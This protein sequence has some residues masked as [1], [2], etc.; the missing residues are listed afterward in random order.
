M[1]DLP[2]PWRLRAVQEQD[3]A[4]LWQLYCSSRDDLQAL[5]ITPEMLE[6]LLKQQW[7][8]HLV[9]CTQSFPHAQYVL[10]ERVQ[11]VG[12]PQAVSIPIGRVVVDVAQDIRLVDIAVL[13][14]ERCQGVAAAVLQALQAQGLPVSLAVSLRNAQALRLYE[15]LGFTAQ[16]DDGV[17]LQM[18]WTGEAA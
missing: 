15:R 4:F 10:I 8:A 16:S 17:Q 9:G 12:D 18:R 1:Y 7:R 11:A 5:P 14:Q 6:R 2:S 3:A 13:P